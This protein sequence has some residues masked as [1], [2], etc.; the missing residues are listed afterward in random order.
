MQKLEIEIFFARSTRL[1]FDAI[2]PASRS[3]TVQEL[4]R[5]ELPILHSNFCP[6][7]HRQRGFFLTTL[8]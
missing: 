3:Q 1:P 7:Q 6:C 5:I 8:H 4:A 2:L